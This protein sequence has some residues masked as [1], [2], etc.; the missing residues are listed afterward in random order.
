MKALSST[1][2][3]RIDLLARAYPRLFPR[4][5]LL[6]LVREQ[7]GDVDTLDRWIRRR[8]SHVRARSPRIIYHIC[9]G[10]LAVSA[11]TS[12]AHGLLVGAHNVV[13]LPGPREDDATRREITA[14]VRGLPMQLRK[15]VRLQ[16]GRDEKTMQRADIVIAFGSD[17]TM[18]TLRAQLR[19][20]QK[21]IAHGHAVSLL[22]IDRPEHLTAT[23]LRACAT[24]VLTYD[25]LGCLS[26][27]AIY[28]SPGHDVEALGRKLAHALETQWH[29]L[30]AKPSRPLG[31]R[32]R[33]AEARDVAWALGHRMW[34][35]PSGHLGWTLMHDP[36]PAF[37]ASPLHGV[38]PIR[39]SAAADLEKNLS[40][41]RGRISTVGI[42]G[43][44]SSSPWRGPFLKLGVSRFCRAGRMQFP[45]LSWH[46]DGRVPLGELVT[47]MDDETTS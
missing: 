37:A 20:D 26:P 6:R 42:A 5:E 10:N 13:K 29:R 23:E 31:V 17:A 14:F 22:W 32:A 25:Q 46:H 45:P 24:D 40:A 11:M 7:L 16:S 8:S 28:L 3:E 44:A 35:P 47:W 36:D 21:F 4:A 9:A 1:T 39:V 43:V 38:I 18:A 12:I 27:Q 34:L 33:I 41:V 19:P 2:R 15:L 30:N